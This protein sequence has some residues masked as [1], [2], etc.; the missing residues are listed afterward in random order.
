M[1]IGTTI[2]GLNV[3][4]SLTAQDEVPLWDVEASGEPT[5]KIT[6][7]N[8]AASVKSLASLPNT[9]EM[10]AAIQQSTAIDDFTSSV[11]ISENAAYTAF[12][13]SGKTVMFTF[14]GEAKQRAE[15]Q[16]LFTLPS[17]YRPL[18]PMYYVGSCN[19][20]NMIVQLLTSG[21][22]IIYNATSYP[23]GRVYLSG[24]YMIA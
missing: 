24:T 6:A 20:I 3:V 14:Q 21:S 13:R 23:T 2:D 9:T 5:K 22:C 17:G 10:N 8:L 16:Q 7:Q 12:V 11:T 4:T 18:K 19:G 15:N 1:A